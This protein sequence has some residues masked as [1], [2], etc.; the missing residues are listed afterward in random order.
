MIRDSTRTPIHT[1]CKY[2]RLRRKE[3]QPHRFRSMGVPVWIRVFY[4]ALNRI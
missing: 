2:D 1:H 3:E 4:I